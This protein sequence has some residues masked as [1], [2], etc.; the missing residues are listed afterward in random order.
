M[1][2]MFVPIKHGVDKD[3]QITENDPDLFNFNEEAEP[4]I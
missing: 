2:R 1:D 4:L 3:T